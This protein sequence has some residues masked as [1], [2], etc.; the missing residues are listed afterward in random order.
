MASVVV[1]LSASSSSSVTVNYTTVSGT[2]VAGTDFTAASGT[3]TFAPGVTSQTI[4]VT[5][6]TDSAATTATAFTVVLSTPANAT[7]GTSQATVTINNPVVVPTISAGNVSVTRPTSGTATASVVV[8]LSASSTNTVTVNYTTT[9]GTAVAGTDFT[10]TSGTLTFAP[11]VTSQTI[12]VTILTDSAK[13]TATGFTVVLST[14]ANAT[15][16]T[17]QATV[18]INNPVVAVVPAVV[19]GNLNATRPAS[20]V[21]RRPSSSVLPH[22]LPTP[23]RS[24]TPPLAAVPWLVQTLRP[25]AV[26]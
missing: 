24:T 15:L 3:L 22:R 14:P 13:T 8:S 7:L 10:A 4:P 16:G 6:L 20:P 11:G 5:I 21:P 19:I 1:S 23:S 25:P 26:R 18:T 2:A 12:P 17:S 9:S